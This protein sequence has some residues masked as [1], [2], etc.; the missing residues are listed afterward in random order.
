M[1]RIRCL[2]MLDPALA[3]TWP[4][5]REAQREGE[6]LHIVAE[7][8]EPVLRRLLEADAGARDVEVG[9]ASL[10]DAFLSLTRPAVA[11]AA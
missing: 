10:A 9:R 4:G 8:A 5:V 11:Q 1:R 6:A 2:S 3:A 7:P